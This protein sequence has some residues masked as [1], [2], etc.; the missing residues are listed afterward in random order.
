MARSFQQEEGGGEGGDE[1]YGFPPQSRDGVAPRL[2][3]SA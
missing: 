3:S 2:A 1:V